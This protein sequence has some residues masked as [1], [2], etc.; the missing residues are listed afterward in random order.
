MQLAGPPGGADDLVGDGIFAQVREH[1]L[2]IN[3]Q[4]VFLLIKDHRRTV[5]A[6]ISICE[7]STLG[8]NL[9]QL[10]GPPGGTDDLV[11]DGI[12]AQVFLLIERP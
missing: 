12:F 6:S 7:S 1:G 5:L 8:E 11:G 10:A 4:T 2:S 3:R 9:V